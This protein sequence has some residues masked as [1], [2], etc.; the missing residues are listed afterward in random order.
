VA[1]LPPVSVKLP[2]GTIELGKAVELPIRLNRQIQGWDMAFKNTKKADF[3]VGQIHASHVVDRSAAVLRAEPLD[4]ARDNR[5]ARCASRRKTDPSGV[6]E[7][8]L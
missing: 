2:N 3:V 8:V 4:F 1:N 7:I 5:R 6:G